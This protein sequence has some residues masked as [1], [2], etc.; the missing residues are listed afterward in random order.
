MD[1]Q[2][3][4]FLLSRGFEVED[5]LQ[6]GP[7]SWNFESEETEFTPS[8][9]CVRNVADGDWIAVAYYP[10]ARDD[11]DTVTEAHRRNSILRRI[12]VMQRVAALESPCES[13]APLLEKLEDRR[14]TYIL[15]PLY[16]ITLD[17]WMD[18][19]RQYKEK[20][21]F[22]QALRICIQLA[23][24]VG[25]LHKM[26][27]IHRNIMAFNVMLDQKE[28]AVLVGYGQASIPHADFQGENEL[29]RLRF[30]DVIVPPEQT[31]HTYATDIW[32]LGKLFLRLFSGK[33]FPGPGPHNIED[34][35]FKYMGSSQPKLSEVI[36]LLSRMLEENPRLRYNIENV[37]VELSLILEPS[38][39]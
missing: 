18:T 30:N 38:Y 17:E 19:K 34:A 2:Q 6:E 14:F 24:A 39:C 9:Y 25:K 27:V 37:L 5:A 8:H 10:K 33:L 4:Q 20:V 31:S 1:E 21:S 12:W 23:T 26:R 13:L 36:R 15:M 7:I 28:N 16:D 11:L 35:I 22:N 3:I 32:A 29:P